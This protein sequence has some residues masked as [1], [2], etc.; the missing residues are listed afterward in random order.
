MHLAILSLM[1][2][3][4]MSVFQRAR[5]PWLLFKKNTEAVAIK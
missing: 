5:K 2:L 3:P 4:E 1:R